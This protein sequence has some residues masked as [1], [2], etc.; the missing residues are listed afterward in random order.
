[1][2]AQLLVRNAKISC[3]S[4]FWRAGLASNAYLR[5]DGSICWAGFYRESAS[6]EIMLPEAS[7]G[8]LRSGKVGFLIL[9]WRLRI[10][11]ANAGFWVGSLWCGARPHSTEFGATATC[12]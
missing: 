8:Y 1:M 9:L 5:I 7:C 3:G 10:T 12:S 11:D 6:F 4:G 2:I